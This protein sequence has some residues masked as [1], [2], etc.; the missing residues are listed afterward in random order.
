MTDTERIDFLQ[1]L[2]HLLLK[3]NV[4]YFDK[5]IQFIQPPRILLL[6]FVMIFGLGFLALNVFAYPNSQMMM[7]WINLMVACILA[8]LFSIPKSFYNLKTM[9]AVLSLP[10]GMILMLGSLLKIKGAN[11]QFIHTQHGAQKS[12]QK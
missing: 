8:F 5:A 7:A 6:G 1:S 11:K 2:K 12:N 4:D 9:K 10:K 3:G